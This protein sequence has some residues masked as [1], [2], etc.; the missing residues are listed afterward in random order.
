MCHGAPP[1]AEEGG[2][3]GLESH[4][5]TP[6]IHV[7][8]AI[9]WW[10]RMNQAVP[11]YPKGYPLEHLIGACCPGGIA[12]VAEG[13]TRALENIASDYAYYAQTRQTPVLPDHGVPEH[14]V[15]K[16][17]SGEEFPKGPSDGDGDGGTGGPKSGFTPR[18]QATVLGGGRFA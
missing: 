1:R 10:H 14:N 6:I 16:R 15:F 17:V 5:V 3:A 11:K 12:S 4:V 13:V 7:V 9:K 18:R 2:G 8:K